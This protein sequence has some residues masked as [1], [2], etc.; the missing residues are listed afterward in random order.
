MLTQKVKDVLSALCE[1][2]GYSLP[3]SDDEYLEVLWVCGQGVE[4]LDRVPRRWWDRLTVVKKFDLGQQ[5]GVYYIGYGWA[6]ANGDQTIFD[7]GWQFDQDTI[8]FYKPKEVVRT[9]YV[10][11]DEEQV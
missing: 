4:E 2:E 7:L 9:T 5:Q 3:S 1:K 10:K 11:I 6:Q 8:A